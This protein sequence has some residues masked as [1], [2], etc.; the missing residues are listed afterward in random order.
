MCLCLAFRGPV[1]P[2][3]NVTSLEFCPLQHRVC[4]ELLQKKS[5]VV[6]I[7][8]FVQSCEGYYNILHLL[9]CCCSI[10]F[11]GLGAYSYFMFNGLIINHLSQ[12]MCPIKV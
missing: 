11:E 3:A 4:M 2:Y 8:A 7:L 9:S 12:E 6:G 5:A 10:Y 1:V